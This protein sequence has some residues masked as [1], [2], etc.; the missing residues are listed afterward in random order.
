MASTDTGCTV[1][2]SKQTVCPEME[3]EVLKVF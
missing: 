1:G 3:V 2:S